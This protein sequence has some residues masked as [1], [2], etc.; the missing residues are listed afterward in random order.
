[1][2][3]LIDVDGVLANCAKQVLLFS[4]S[5]IEEKD[6]VNFGIIEALSKKEQELLMKGMEGSIFWHTLEPIEGAIEN[7][8]YLKKKNHKLVI[9]TTPWSSCPVW[10]SV[11]RKWL[12]KIFG[13]NTFEDII[14]VNKKQFVKGDL[15]IDDKVEN[16]DN[17]LN[18][19]HFKHAFIYDYPYNRSYKRTFN[20]KRITWKTFKKEFENIFPPK[21]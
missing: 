9:V 2:R 3:I 5:T 13:K 19:H 17:W 16:I 4:G 15:F 7:I 1:M 20:C 10:E 14:F 12:K 6:V 8:K 11:R 18:E 21:L